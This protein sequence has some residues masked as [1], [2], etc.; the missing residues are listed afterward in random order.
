MMVRSLFLSD[1]TFWRY[2][3]A[4]T[5]HIAYLF[6]RRSVMALAPAGHSTA[7]RM[8]VPEPFIIERQGAIRE[9][10]LGPRDWMRLDSLQLLTK[11]LNVTPKAAD[12]QQSD[13]GA[14]KG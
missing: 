12:A 9:S 6:A 2:L 10:V 7:S 8:G 3:A 5:L 11:L 1:M 13:R 4:R 14:R